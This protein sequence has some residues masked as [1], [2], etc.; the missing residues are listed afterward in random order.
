MTN[1]KF[2]IN[3]R[4]FS[5]GVSTNKPIKSQENYTPERLFG[6]ITFLR[7][8]HTKADIFTKI[9]NEFLRLHNILLH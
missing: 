8:G 9:E 3:T 4:L 2:E 7:S 6:K 1:K 5:N